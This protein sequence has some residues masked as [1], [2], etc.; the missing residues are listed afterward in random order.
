MNTAHTDT[1]LQLKVTL[2]YSKPPIW[3]RIQIADDSTFLDLHAAIQDAFGWE[4]RHLHHFIFDRDKTKE[5][6]FIAPY[7]AE[8]FI[9][10]LTEKI[11]YVK[12]WLNLDSLRCTYE[13]DFGD[14][15]D[16]TV[17]F[18]KVLPA[19]PN[20][21][22][23]RCVAGKRA[24]PPEDCGGV[25][26]Y[27]QKLDTLKHPRSEYYAEAKQWMG[28]FDPEHFDLNEIDFKHVEDHDVER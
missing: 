23:P 26:G 16:H 17:L 15:W 8:D 5:P 20:V 13:Y 19:D 4:D 14:S 11:E 9:E 24:C 28:D 2:K 25:P 10:K 21:T 6:I 3:R 27:E 18:E 7:S 12:D 22:Y 1:V